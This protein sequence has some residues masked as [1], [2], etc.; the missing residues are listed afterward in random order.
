MDV[1]RVIIKYEVD[2]FLNLKL[3]KIHTPLGYLNNAYHHGALLQ[4][5][6]S[7]PLLVKFEDEGGILPIHS[8]G[9]WVS[10]R[11]IGP[12]SFGYDFTVGNGIGPNNPVADDN[13]NKSFSFG[14]HIKPM[15]YL[16]VGVSTYY[17]KLEI[18][19]L[20]LNGSL[21]S[22]ALDNSML[23]G[24]LAYTSL[25]FESIGEYDLITNETNSDKVKTKAYFIYAGY[26]F[27]KITPY[28]RYDN[29]KFGK[30]EPYYSMNE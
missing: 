22:E 14:A 19:E 5:I 16:E 12:L 6:I 17:D 1:E 9:L 10:E 24:H 25:G 3:G 27:E 7:R 8:T 20:S 29:L 2:Y 18:G 26:N 15:E 23:V 21:L 4:P 28:L 13:D 11:D 30:S